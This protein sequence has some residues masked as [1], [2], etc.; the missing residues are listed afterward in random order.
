MKKLILISLLTLG[1]S[2]FAADIGIRVQTPIGNNSVLDIG[3]RSDD[4]RYDNRYKNFDYNRNGYRDDFGYFYG[5]FDRVGYFY[6]NIFFTYDSR[7]TYSDRLHHRGYFKHNHPHYREYRYHK[8]NDWNKT[9]NYREVNKPIYGAYY[10][11]NY[12]QNV[13]VKK[14]Y[15]EERKDRN[16]YNHK[17]Y[18]ERS[19][20]QNQRDYGNNNN[21]RNDKNNKQRN[22]EEEKNHR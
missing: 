22:K 4:H 21:Q 12:K 1:S 2:L 5:Y 9:R 17:D 3:F 11:K 14:V 19:S 18:K 6:N 8:N 15:K 10:D 7:Y 16:N 13:N 20:N